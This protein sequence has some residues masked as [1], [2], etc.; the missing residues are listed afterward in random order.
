MRS[1]I[2]TPLP[3][4]RRLT[5]PATVPGVASRSPILPLAAI[6]A[7]DRRQVGDKAWHLARL[8]RAGLPVPAAFC[9]AADAFPDDEAAPLPVALAEAIRHAWRQLGAAVVAVR[10]SAGDEDQPESSAAGRYASFLGIRDE[11]ALLAAIAACRQARLAPRA[12]LGRATEGPPPPLAVL[13]QVQVEVEAAGVLFTTDPLNGAADRL[14]INAVWG[15]GEP[16]ASGRVSGDVFHAAADGTLL[17]CSVSV[18]ERMLTSAGEQ[19]VPPGQRRRPALTP[20]QLRRL[21]GLAR[22]V[23]Q[24]FG[25]PAGQ[26][27]DLEFAVAGGQPLLLQARPVPPR[28]ANRASLP[29]K[30]GETVHQ[31]CADVLTDALAAYLHAEQARLGKH[32][33]QLRANGQ[34]EGDEVVWS[35]GNIRELLPT[36]SAFSFGLFRHIFAGRDGAIVRGRRRLGYRLGP[37]AGEDLF[38]LIA[39]QPYFNLE[40][41]AATYDAGLPLPVAPLLAAVAADPGSANYPELGL[42]PR[43]LAATPGGNDAAAAWRTRMLAHAASF[44]PRCARLLP[45]LEALRQRPGAVP[46]DLDGL[47]LH[48]A[49]ASELA[50][51]RQIGVRFVIAARLGFFFADLLRRRLPVVFPELAPARCERLAANLLQ[52]LPG[53]RITEQGLDLERLAAGELDRGTYLARYGHL[54]GNELELLLPRLDEVPARLE[55]Q[56][57]ELRASGRHPG[58][59]FVHQQRRRQRS[60]ALLD[61]RLAD[62]PADLAALLADLH[63]AQTYLPLRETLKYHLAAGYARLR[64]LLITLAGR[65]GLATDALFHLTP[66]E[67]LAL[68]GGNADAASAAAE[69]SEQRRAERALTRR[70]A[71]ERPLPPVLFASQLASLGSPGDSGE[72]AEPEGSSNLRGNPIAPGIAEGIVR[73]L[74]LDEDELAATLPTQLPEFTGS[75]IIVAPAANLGLAPLFRAAAGVVVEVGG[76]LAH[77]ACQAR[78]AGI[79]ALVLANAMRLLQ[80]GDRVRVDA[81]RGL[82]TVLARANKL[83]EEVR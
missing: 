62:H 83:R 78:E 24:H 36:P 3:P 17:D 61:R 79:P 15:L 65:R 47:A 13:V 33:A 30:S 23:T 55:R 19:P 8:H 58:R 46:A 56:V 10:S 71:T 1:A 38:V 63:A 67:V 26:A 44:A 28:T 77:S 48:A 52:G 43:V 81:N 40:I 14:V 12:A 68:A 76:V 29:A 64:A 72:P 69:L 60:E 50:R 45:W 53:S 82:L 66:E 21:A 70:L 59:E 57:A 25:A 2:N 41:D 39:G 27:L 74:C 32:V 34:I 18:K 16:L 6:G 5:V 4:V 9:I 35:G 49:I 80:D 20:P 42:Y 75:E 73:R 22:L 51:L 54:A 37:Q 11:A 7:A 31:S